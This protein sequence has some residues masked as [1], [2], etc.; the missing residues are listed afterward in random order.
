[1]TYVLGTLALALL[2]LLGLIWGRLY[3]VSGLLQQTN[4]RLASSSQSEIDHLRRLVDDLNQ[5]NLALVD[6]AA[7]VRLARQRS[8]ETPIPQS[9]DRSDQAEQS[10]TS[11]RANPM[12]IELPEAWRSREKAPPA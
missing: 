8:P 3:Q 4:T 2:A 9:Y 10:W 7:Q 11:Q 5:Q 1:M 6:A 12:V